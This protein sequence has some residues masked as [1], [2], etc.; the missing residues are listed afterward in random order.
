MQGKYRKPHPDSGK[1]RLGELEHRNREL[2]MEMT[3]RKGSIP[4]L[5]SANGVTARAAP[6]QNEA[7]GG[8]QTLG[9]CCQRTLGLGI[10][11]G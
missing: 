7:P 3:S 10:T 9:E 2:Q 5:D 11:Q 4:D 1:A 8:P 6:Q